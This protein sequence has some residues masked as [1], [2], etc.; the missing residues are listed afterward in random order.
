MYSKKDDFPI[1]A[2]FCTA[3]TH[4]PLIRHIDSAVVVNV[5]AVGLPF[6]GDKRAAYAQIT[7]QDGEWQPDIIRLDYDL[8]R[9]EQDFFDSGFLQTTK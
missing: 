5:G 6:D 2:L 3:H 8:Q 4:W 7:W 1:P 9:A